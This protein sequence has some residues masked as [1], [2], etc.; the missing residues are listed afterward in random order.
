MTMIS[1]DN[2]TK[3]LVFQQIFTFL[4]LVKTDLTKNVYEESILVAAS[5]P[6]VNSQISKMTIGPGITV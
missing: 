3:I 6:C 4:I 2:Y 1:L 5:N